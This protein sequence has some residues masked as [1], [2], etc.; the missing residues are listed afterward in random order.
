MSY[1]NTLHEFTS[2]YTTGDPN[3]SHPSSLSTGSGVH[4]KRDVTLNLSFMD[5]MGGTLNNLRALDDN[6][7]FNYYNVSILDETGSLLYENYKTGVVSSNFSLT[8]AD[9]I[10]LFDTYSGNFGIRVD[11][12]DKTTS[13]H[14]QS[15]IYVYGN[16]PKYNSINV[17]DGSGYYLYNSGWDGP[18]TAYNLPGYFDGE[19]Y[20]WITP[21]G[22]SGY[23]GELQTGALVETYELWWSGNNMDD[24]MKYT[25][26]GVDY[27][28][29]AINKFPLF[30]PENFSTPTAND[31]IYDPYQATA[32]VVTDRAFRLV[33]TTDAPATEY[34]V[35]YEYY[36][37]NTLTISVPSG[38]SVPSLTDLTV[39]NWV[40]TEDTATGGHYWK[41]IAS[42]PLPSLDPV[43]GKI[44][45][46]IHFQNN[47][48]HTRFEKIDIYSTTGT[49]DIRDT[50]PSDFCKTIP[51][52]NQDSTVSFQINL[53][54]AEPDQELYFHMVPGGGL[55]TGESWIIGPHKTFVPATPEIVL[56]VRQ[57]DL[58]EGDS[59][60]NMNLITGSITD[61]YSG[62]D[63]FDTG[64][65][66]TFEYTIQVEDVSNHIST[67]K[68]VV[69]HTGTGIEDF[70]YSE[71]DVSD[72]THAEFQVTGG[73]LEAQVSGVS[74]SPAT[75][76]MFRTSM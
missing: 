69:T 50:E 51:I 6:Q 7:F 53:D 10:N 70:S 34:G 63:I 33:R 42:P 24:T 56:G 12:Y 28:A 1:P 27:F 23:L 52:F 47:P 55:G 20:A 29:N 2:S 15:D 48:Q 58:L 26:G 67:H 31:D 17:R 66:N 5:R 72:G 73:A 16:V 13:T 76:R 41:Q 60:V 19:L 43:T 64:T 8:E 11:T 36:N 40:S 22:Y 68:I 14:N 4:L 45:V 18:V 3:L 62:I 39:Q 32:G 61:T 25:T 37:G 21:T 54:K 75:Y 46:D 44:E 71:Y 30:A 35:S 9:N 65:Y 59:K 38:D 49:G 57:V 74:F